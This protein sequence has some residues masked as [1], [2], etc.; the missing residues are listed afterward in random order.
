[1]NTSYWTAASGV[2][3]LEDG[4]RVEEVVFAVAPPLVLAAAVEIPRAAAPRWKGHGVAPEN[5]AGDDVDADAADPRRRPRE[6]LI[7]ECPIEADRF[8][9]L[10]AAVALQRGDAH[11]GHHL[12]DALVQRMDVVDHRLVMGDA[13]ELPLPDHVVERFE[14]QIRVDDAGAV[15]E[16]QRAVVHL[17]RVARFH[18]Q[19]ALRARAL[20]HRDGGARR[21]LPAGSESAPDRDPR[22]GRRG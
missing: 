18:D 11:L 10:R 4:V 22:R 17:A 21:P 8:E 3:Q 12:Q 14:R 19:A 7:H 15:A 6:V 1:L 13:D 9:D 20:A 5:L 16:E 2:L